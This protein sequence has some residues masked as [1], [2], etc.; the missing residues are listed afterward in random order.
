MR[1]KIFGLQ[2]F[3]AILELTILYTFGYLQRVSGGTD[4]DL[5]LD[6]EEEANEAVDREAHFNCRFESHEDANSVVV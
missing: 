3:K 1:R 6:D 4:H 5:A 2:P